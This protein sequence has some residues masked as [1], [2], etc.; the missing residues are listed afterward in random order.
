MVYWVNFAGFI[1]LSKAFS[2]QPC[3]PNSSAIF[4]PTQNQSMPILQPK[5]GKFCLGSP[6]FTTTIEAQRFRGEARLSRCGL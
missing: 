1:W 5:A 6:R 2:A 4:L 3:N